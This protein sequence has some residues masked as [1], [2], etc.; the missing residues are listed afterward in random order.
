MLDWDD[1]RY[2]LASARAGNITAAAPELDV[3]ESTKNI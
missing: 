2:V 1:L 3:H